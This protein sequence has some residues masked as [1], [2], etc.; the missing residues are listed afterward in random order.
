MSCKILAMMTAIRK[1]Q[2]FFIIGIYFQLR[3]SCGLSYKLPYNGVK[4]VTYGEPCHPPRYLPVKIEEPVE[5][6]RPVLSLPTPCTYQPL[7]LNYQVIVDKPIPYQSQQAK[8]SVS[9]QVPEV[10]VET[11][12][13]IVKPDPYRGKSYVY[14]TQAP[15]SP[16]VPILTSHNFDLYVPPSPTPTELPT[17]K[18]VK[19]LTGLTSRI[20][21]VLIP[22]CE[23]PAKCACQA[24]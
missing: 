2:Y 12:Q 5:P 16:S 22:A 21:R 7:K 14:N 17:P 24:R 11:V 18:P 9:I 13:E 6:V 4:I 3:F 1:L 8:Y 10:P 23:A 15:P 19:L 20:D